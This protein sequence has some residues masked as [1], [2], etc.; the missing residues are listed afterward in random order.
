MYYKIV[1]FLTVAF[2]G[3]GCYAYNDDVSVSKWSPQY[4]YKSIYRSAGYPHS[5]ADIS[6]S[7]LHRPIALYANRVRTSTIALSGIMTKKIDNFHLQ[8]FQSSPSNFGNGILGSSRV[9]GFFPSTS[10]VCSLTLQKYFTIFL[11]NLATLR[12]EDS[13]QLSETRV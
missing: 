11:C 7:Y 6:R 9:H 2:I 3:S 13:M 10:K 1:L 12:R 4:L 5:G 8:G